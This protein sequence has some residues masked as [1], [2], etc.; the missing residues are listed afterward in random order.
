LSLDWTMMTVRC[1]DEAPYGT[2][3]LRV[4]SPSGDK[5]VLKSWWLKLYGSCVGAGCGDGSI[6]PSWILT[7]GVVGSVVGGV[8]TTDTAP[9]ATSSSI[10]NT[11]SHI[12][13]TTTSAAAVVATTLFPSFTTGFW[14]PGSASW[15][16]EDLDVGTTPAE[17]LLKTPTDTVVSS[18]CYYQSVHMSG[19]L[20]EL[21][22]GAVMLISFG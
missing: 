6:I 8:T 16:D 21:M 3:T 13:A 11:P 17:I 5:S 2:Y 12:V 14:A 19:L 7:Q 4:T 20:A 15:W 18:G 22:V 1:W 10:V 9:G